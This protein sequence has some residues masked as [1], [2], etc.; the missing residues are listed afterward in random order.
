MPWLQ[1]G[2]WGGVEKKPK[3]KEVFSVFFALLINLMGETGK[4]HAV[5]RSF[6]SALQGREI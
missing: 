3:W 2:E 6:P 1:M 4:E 5:S